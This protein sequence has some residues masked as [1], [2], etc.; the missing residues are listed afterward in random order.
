MK[1]Q[2]TPIMTF[3]ENY[4]TEKTMFFESQSKFSVTNQMNKDLTGD[5]TRVA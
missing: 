4:G 3:V 2:K 1:V 5:P